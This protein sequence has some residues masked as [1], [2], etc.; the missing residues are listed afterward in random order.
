[1][2]KV[3]IIAINPKYR[4]VPYFC[5]PVYDESIREY[6]TG[7]QGLTDEEL[8]K[9]PMIIDP[10]EQFAIRHMM[11][12]DTNMRKDELMLHLARTQLEVATDANSVVPGKHLFYIENLEEEA[13]TRITKMDL[14]FEALTKVKENTSLGKQR[15]VAIFL[16]IDYTQPAS[17]VQDRI[18][19]KCQNEPEAVL[20]FFMAGSQMRLFAKKLISYNIIKNMGGRYIDGDIFLGRD[21]TEVIHFLQDKKNDPLIARWSIRLEKLE[22]GKVTDKPSDPAPKA[23]AK[24]EADMSLQKSAPK[25]EA[26]SQP[27]PP[28][29][30][31]PKGAEAEKKPEEPTEKPA[32][33]PA[34]KAAP[35]APKK[36]AT[37]K[38]PAAPKA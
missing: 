24:K 5:V 6:N 16:G 12:F 38:K 33:K 22:E 25:P 28:P 3:R 20:A 9:E 30:P 27:A 36:P 21:E 35:L 19:Q 11:A 31:E 37:P 34:S 26:A 8:A 29:P 32:E 2:A 7:Q 14:F 10:E 18:Y 1:M 4:T 17:V 23:P 13:G 15:D